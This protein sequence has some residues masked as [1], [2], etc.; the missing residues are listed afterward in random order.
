M[1]LIEQLAAARVFDLEQ[2]RFAGMPA[3]STA[4]IAVTAIRTGR[5][6]TGL[7]QGRPAC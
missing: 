4:C 2:P 1:T 6:S 7:A 3:I 5:I